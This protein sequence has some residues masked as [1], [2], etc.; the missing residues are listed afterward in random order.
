M[1]PRILACLILLALAG[2]AQRQKVV[3]NAETPEGALLQQFGQEQEDAKKIA[4][5][6]EF[7]AK[8]PQ[9]EGVPWVMGLLQP[10][11]LKTNQLDKAIATGEKL[12]A[13]DPDDAEIAHN[14]LKAA[15][16]KKDADLILQWSNRTS[17]VARKVAAKPKP[18][19]EDE[20]EAWKYSVDYARQL[21]T[22]TEYAL[23]R[24]ML[25]NTDPKKKIMLAEALENRNPAS[26]YVP[27]MAGQ[28]FIAY[29][30]VGNRDRALAIAFKTVATDQT[31][32][33]MLLA[34]ADDALQKKDYDRAIKHSERLVAL[35]ASKAKPDGVSD[36]D[37]R[38]KK[39]MTTGVGSWIAGMSYMAKKQ[40]A[41][42]DKALRVAIPLVK[43]NDQMLAAALFNAG[44]ANHS[45][46]RM[47]DAANFFEQCAKI[48]S[49]FQAQA[50]QNVKAIRGR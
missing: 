35:M 25:E 33:D 41:P 21:D 9:H 47:N 11:Y 44:L 34:V 39:E 36:D 3:I 49:P 1:L 4:V 17:A 48:K 8:F 16:A 6:E 22:Y 24:A 19:S 15:E 10:L 27:Q 13:G 12:L 40:F 7:L 2:A 43:N 50:Q 23:Y 45:L 30:Q 20:V 26:Q 32:E 42:A 5:A 28:L 29:Q 38:K 31:N 14:T 37:W 46:K 18:S